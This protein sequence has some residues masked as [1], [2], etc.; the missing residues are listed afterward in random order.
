[1][2]SADSFPFD[3]GGAF[4]ACFA[5]FLP[6][7]F[8]FAFIGVLVS[9]GIGAVRGR[10][11]P[12]LDGRGAE[13]VLSL[14]LICFAFDAASGT[15]RCWLP[16][17]PLESACLRFARG[18]EAEDEDEAVDTGLTGRVAVGVRVEVE[19]E[20]FRVRLRVVERG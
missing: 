13:L 19:A 16:S 7:P 5:P 3:V 2:I 6:L 10:D 17:L 15:L 14:G 9:V 18:T 20:R 12:P 4:V 8:A 11:L 1:M